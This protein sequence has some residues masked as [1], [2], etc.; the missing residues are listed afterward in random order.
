MSQ[1]SDSRK[2][3]TPTW[4]WV[5]IGIIVATLTVACLIYIGW[6][7]AETHVDTPAGD[8]VTQQYELTEPQADQPGEADWQNAD[9]RSLQDV[10]V[11]PAG[12]E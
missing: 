8:N 11:D 5:V 4:V 1:N 6:F 2:S 7:D 12:A 3:S 10:I 9:H